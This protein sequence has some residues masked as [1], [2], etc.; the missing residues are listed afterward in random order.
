MTNAPPLAR[1]RLHRV[2]FLLAGAYN[3]VWGAYAALRPQA[4]FATA[5]LDPTPYPQ[6][7]ACLGM[8]VGVYG[9]LYL[10]VA[11]V[12]ERGWPIAAVGLLG[13]VLGPLGMLWM[14]G[15]GQW[16][17]AALWL[18]VT[19]D[20]L[21]WLPFGWYLRDAWPHFRDDLQAADEPVTGEPVRDGVHA[22]LLGESWEALAAPLQAFH[23]SDERTAWSG[24]ACVTRGRSPE[25]RLLAATMPFPSAGDDHPLTLVIE[26]GPAGQVWRREFAGRAFRSHQH[27]RADRLLAERMRFVELL[28][29]LAA[30]DGAL[31][32]EHRA[33]RLCLG[34]VRLPLPGWLAPRIEAREWLS[35]GDDRLRA[36][37]VARTA[38]GAEILSYTGVFQAAAPD[39]EP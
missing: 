26:P 15:T 16:P 17:A 13:K 20:F 24:T 33:T 25:A 3:L 37:V 4:F 7:F 31:V 27:A 30:V 8:V 34:P 21:W 28:F 23:R 5:G 38:R 10:E 12:P 19:N 9:L 2:T 14:V 1:R 39:V 35:D 32:Y 6:V 18:C 22:F 36:R 11:R 29:R